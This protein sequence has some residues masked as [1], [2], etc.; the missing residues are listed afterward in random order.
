V[1]LQ[2]ARKPRVLSIPV[3][4]LAGRARTTSVLRVEQL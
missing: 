3:A 1:H 4:D 2:P